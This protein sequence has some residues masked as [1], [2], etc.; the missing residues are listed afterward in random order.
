MPRLAIQAA[1]SQGASST[2]RLSVMRRIRR[3]GK[4]LILCVEN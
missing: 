1:G 4:D 3:A 2:D